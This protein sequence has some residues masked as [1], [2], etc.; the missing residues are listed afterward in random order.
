MPFLLLAIIAVMTAGLIFQPFYS[1]YSDLQDR[2]YQKKY[3]FTSDLVVVAIDDE[4][5]Q[6]LGRWPWDRR[7]YAEFLN[8]LQGS[9][10]RAIGMDIIF[11]EPS[12]P[13]AD[14]EFSE[15]LSRAGNVV[16]PLYINMSKRSDQDR[17]FFY[18]KE[19]VL[20]IPELAEAAELAHINVM[21]DEDGILRQWIP[22]IHYD[23]ESVFSYSKELA[24]GEQK[25][26]PAFAWKLF[27]MTREKEES[28]EELPYEPND[29]VNLMYSS[30]FDP[31]E[32]DAQEIEHISFY[33]VLYGEVPP[34]YFTDKIILVGP[35][36][37]G[38]ADDYYYT[39]LNHKLQTYGIDVHAN[40]INQL[41]HQKFML[42]LSTPLQ[43][44]LMLIFGVLAMIL[45]E[46]VPKIPNALK[47]LVISVFFMGMLLFFRSRNRMIDIFYFML[48][49]VLQGIAKIVISY[50]YERAE[51]YRVKKLFG[52]Y[53]TP[54]LIELMLDKKNASEIKL[55]GEKR[56]ITVL[57]V[58]IRGFTT[59]S[60]MVQPEEV[61]LILNDY[62]TLCAKSIFDYGGMLDKYIG[63]AAMGIYNAPF[64][65]ENHSLMAVR[66]A[67][68]MQQGAV[69]LNKVILQKTGRTIQFGVGIN[70]GDA[71][72]GNIGADFRMDYT[73]IG[74]TVN[75]AARIES[76]SKA[77]QILIS[78]SVYRKVKDFVK[79]ESLGTIHVKGKANELQIYQ[80][81]GMEEKI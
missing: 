46:K 70:T 39:A 53:M 45:Y 47:F 14:A 23:E 64:P 15:A 51:K 2:F 54:D 78:E 33:Q 17:N 58:D 50:L 28:L 20:P 61:V 65:L 55:G 81:I 76:N 30:L 13:E 62:L 63:D 3:D 79:V 25:K 10:V 29:Q 67:W 73:A 49:I 11:A 43:I 5:L 69:E 31:L 52:K 16:L 77:G 19:I 8:G 57:F 34:E 40:I 75:T 72:V 71:V 56:D 12:D 35:T 1:W 37:V 22:R 27:S 44:G 7:V 36:A 38:M 21:T 18:A 68:A 42:R 32:K 26:I 59:M 9:G 24:T 80:V 41:M 60:E 48:L 6:E 4:S 74:D 66:S